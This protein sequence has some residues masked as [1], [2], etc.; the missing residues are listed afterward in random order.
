[1]YV[2]V[3]VSGFHLLGGG[4]ELGRGGGHALFYNVARI[5][6]NV[7]GEV[8]QFGLCGGGEVEHPS[9]NTSH[10]LVKKEYQILKE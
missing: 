8:E 10:D 1:M 5:K 6:F 3:Y 4:G 7:G 2:C 9:K